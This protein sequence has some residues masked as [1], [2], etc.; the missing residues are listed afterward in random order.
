MQSLLYS[1]AREGTNGG[2][3]VLQADGPHRGLPRC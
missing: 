2:S 1:G 3:E